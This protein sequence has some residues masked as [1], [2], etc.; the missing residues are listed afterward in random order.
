MRIPVRGNPEPGRYSLERTPYFREPLEACGRDDPHDYVVVM[1]TPQ[2]GAS[3]FSRAAI[4]YWVD[5][6]AD[7]IL[8][9][10]PTQD[11][12]EEQIIE[13]VV[14]AI[15]ETPR[16]ARWI[17]SRAKDI[18]I[19]EV[20]LSHL[21]IY[22]G[23]ATSPQALASRPVARVVLDETDKYAGNAKEAEPEDL[24]EHR[25]NT[26]KHRRKILAIS[27]PTTKTGTIYRMFR[28]SRDKRH[29]HCACPGCGELVRWEWSH[30]R[31]DRQAEVDPTDEDQAIELI[32]QLDVGDATAWIVCPS[33]ETKVTETQR[34][35][36]VNAGCYQSEGYPPGERPRSKRVAYHVPAWISP[37]VT[38]SD[39]VAAYLRSRYSEDARDFHNGFLALPS[40]EVSGTVNGDVFTDRMEA[41]PHEVPAWCT[42]LVA[43]ADTQ[44]R[45]G[46]PYWVWTVRAFGKAN[47]SQLV[48]FGVAHTWAAL[49]ESTVDAEFAVS[50]R[51][52]IG[53]DLIMVDTGGGVE[54]EDGNTTHIVY[55]GA[56]ADPARVVPVK[57]ASHK[58]DRIIR[59][60]DV[61]YVA[62][63]NAR[64][65]HVHLHT[66]DTE[67][68][69]DVLV[70]LIRSVDPVLWFENALVTPDY[71]AQMTS[72]EKT[73]VRVGRKWVRKWFRTSKARND[74]W[75]ATVYALAGAIMMRA[76]DRAA[77]SEQAK[78][79]GEERPARPAPAKRG[80]IN[81]RRKRGGWINKR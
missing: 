45:A 16:L 5:T 34:L 79:K 73:R 74:L 39:V 60:S 76:H 19:S 38:F 49:I 47:K 36:A 21:S 43:G 77:S 72:E 33:C 40:E 28:Q 51:H 71:V 54:T 22:A 20:S 31:W 58:Q 81:R 68:L 53:A 32:D 15:K 35:P 12:C 57:G 64:K 55:E 24:A 52:P 56:R 17:T 8:L 42:A 9:V 26:Y 13:R 50:G 63:G 80:Q 7:P 29:W 27:T 37:W 18:T 61:A 44:A 6:T 10:Y 70:S 23:W 11:A 25:T 46:K 1:K 41:T 3:T 4:G 59:A 67:R 14:P 69:K 48:A 75:D 65:A 2:T 30:F 66:L 78:T 62:P